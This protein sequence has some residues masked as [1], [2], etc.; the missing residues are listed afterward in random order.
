MAATPLLDGERIVL[1][2]FGPQHLTARY[3]SWLNDP[4]TVRYSEQRHRSHTL[5]SC[6]DW[7]AAMTRPPHHLWAV[8]AA[9]LGHVGNLAA[10]VD[11]AN[12]LAD[13]TILLGEGRGR[14]FG[15]DAWK[16][17]L[18]WLLGP[19]G[20]RK[21]AAGTLAANRPML[22]VMRAAGMVEDGV[23][24]RHYLVDGREEDVVC[25]AA[26]RAPEFQGERR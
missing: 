19:G 17:G 16:T 5:E 20:L 9:S 23:R 13:L 12:A 7:T 22:A 18:S 2:P 14:G 11:P 21:V 1:R 8:E 15:L 6:R 4:L 26:F 25:M 24:R 3:V 10:Y